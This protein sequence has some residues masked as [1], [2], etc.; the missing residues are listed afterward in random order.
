MNVPFQRMTGPLTASPK[1]RLPPCAPKTVIAHTDASIKK[2]RGGVGLVFRT[3]GDGYASKTVFGATAS[4]TIDI[5]RLELSAIF[6]ALETA[7]P[8]ANLVVYSDSQTALDQLLS[9][10]IHKKYRVL[11]ERVLQA[12][13]EREGPAFFSKVKAHSGNAGNELADRLA[14]AGEGGLYV[15][16]DEYSSL[17]EWRRDHVS[18]RHALC[19]LRPRLL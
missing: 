4:E 12:L 3:D 6:L 19:S 8:A 10:K 15:P 9:P 14:G 5:N 7:D 11:T 16:P 2:H 13:E 17:F 1:V 18:D